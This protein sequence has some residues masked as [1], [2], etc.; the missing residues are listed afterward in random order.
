[1]YIALL[2]ETLTLCTA[3][4]CIALPVSQLRGLLV[5]GDLLLAVLGA[6][7]LSAAA[8]LYCSIASGYVSFV[9]AGLHSNKS[10]AGMPLGH[11]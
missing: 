3:L 1:M 5:I 10:A 9:L 8:V 2:C 11:G 6:A 7:Q 4:H